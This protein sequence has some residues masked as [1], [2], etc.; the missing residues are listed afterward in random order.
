MQLLTQ[1]LFLLPSV[2]NGFS[3]CQRR[4]MCDRHAIVCA[5]DVLSLHL[6]VLQH[7]HEHDGADDE[8]E[9]RA[10]H[11]AL[12]I[13]LL[14]RADQRH[15]VAADLPLWRRP[16]Q[17]PRRGAVHWHDDFARVA[18]AARR[19]VRRDVGGAHPLAGAHGGAVEKRHLQLAVVQQHV[20]RVARHPADE[21][22]LS[23]RC[24]VP[25]RSARD[26]VICPPTAAMQNG[27][28]S[29][30]LVGQTVFRYSEQPR[31][32]HGLPPHSDPSGLQHYGSIS[33]VVRYCED[34]DVVV[35][36]FKTSF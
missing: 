22:P 4:R 31:F 23:R 32:Y 2:R 1:A 20:V 12:Q 16:R 19:D 14:L 15:V 34:N 10:A 18:P 26:A 30:S 25:G 36:N 17:R 27:C 5:L 3:I 11:D 9:Q 8:H 21:P 29:E 33:M 13:V 24:C 7:R 6:R 28:Q 35:I